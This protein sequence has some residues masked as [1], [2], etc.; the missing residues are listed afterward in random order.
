M[1]QPLNIWMPS[2]LDIGP[3]YT[4]RVTAIDPTTGAGVAG[5]KS[6]IVVIE[7]EALGSDLQALNVGN[8][9]LVGSSNESLNLPSPQ[10]PGANP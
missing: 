9:I 3:N 1:A 10:A 6:S 5:T 7:A 4:L 2:G 8:A